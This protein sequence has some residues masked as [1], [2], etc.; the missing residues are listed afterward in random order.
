MF[1]KELFMPRS[2][3][4]NNFL[5]EEVCKDKPSR[6]TIMVLITKGADINAKK[7]LG[8]S[9]LIE[10]LLHLA[11]MTYKN[12]DKWSESAFKDLDISIIQLLIDQGADVNYN[13][14]NKYCIRRGKYSLE[15]AALIPRSDLVEMLLKAGANPNVKCDGNWGEPESYYDFMLDYLF[16]IHRK[17]KHFS[18]FLDTELKK[19]KKI[20][21]KYGAERVKD[22]K[23]QDRYKLNKLLL[24]EVRK[25]TPVKETIVDLLDRGADINAIDTLGFNVL[26]NTLSHLEHMT[27]KNGK[28]TEDAVKELDFEI[29]QLL[30]DK[31]ADVNHNWRNHDCL[32]I[33]AL[34][35]RRSDLVEMLLQAG[36]DPNVNCGGDWEEPGPY[37][38]FMLD[39]LEDLYG[40]KINSNDFTGSEMRKIIKL[41]RQYGAE[42]EN[43]KSVKDRRNKAFQSFKTSSKKQALNLT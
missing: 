4:L 37:F 12:G 16:D 20:F 34:G 40:D 7:P 43:D 3:E 21:R 26:M 1:F 2:N 8:D 25:D 15:I 19:I 6:E 5:I 41:F 22:K 33:A 9:V 10:A 30:L 39:Y 13:L 11:H 32:Q 29:I 24:N 31:G 14:H 42:S 35:I 23:V 17:N 28:W 18:D 38:S 36:A 27:Y